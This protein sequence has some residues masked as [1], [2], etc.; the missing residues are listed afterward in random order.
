[1]GHSDLPTEHWREYSKHSTYT[2]NVFDL[3]AEYL[4]GPKSAMI[5]IDTDTG[6]VRKMHDNW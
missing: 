4:F 2:D 5:N 1:M 6:V 3:F